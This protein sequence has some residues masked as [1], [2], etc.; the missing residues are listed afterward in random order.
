MKADGSDWRQVTDVT[1]LQADDHQPHWSGDATQIVFDRSIFPSAQ[2][3]TVKLGTG[4]LQAIGQ[5][6]SGNA[7]W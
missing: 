1:G 4:A 3:Y 7:S 5:P 2:V 6:V